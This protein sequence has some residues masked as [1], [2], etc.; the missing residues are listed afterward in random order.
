MDK[1][2]LLLPTSRKTNASRA[3]TTESFGRVLADLALF[4]IVAVQGKDGKCEIAKWGH[5]EPWI[6]LT[7][8]N[9]GA[10]VILSEGKDLRSKQYAKRIN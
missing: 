4:K 7:R 1:V 9:R 5:L 2:L 10:F 8:Q 3:R 6:A